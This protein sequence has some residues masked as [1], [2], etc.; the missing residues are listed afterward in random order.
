MEIYNL[1]DNKFENILSGVCL[2]SIRETNKSIVKKYD[3]IDEDNFAEIKSDF[4]I[5]IKNFLFLKEYE[6][7]S[8][9]DNVLYA[10]KDD[11]EYEFL[12]DFDWGSEKNQIKIKFFDKGINSG[13]S[14][15]EGRYFFIISIN[16]GFLYLVNC[17]KLKKQVKEDKQQFKILTEQTDLFKSK[18]IEFDL[19]NLSQ[20]IKAFSLKK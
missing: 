15:F 9:Q 14:N 10:K 20:K 13:I 5:F 1:L 8:V 17:E 3:F 6:I 19:N 7:I 16:K 18:F 4:L 2:T 12:I 11:Q